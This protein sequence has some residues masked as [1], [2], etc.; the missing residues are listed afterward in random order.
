VAFG[1]SS[2][3][4]LT[5]RASAGS[6]ARTLGVTVR[7]STFPETKAKM[8]PLRSISIALLISSA[9]ACIP[10]LAQDTQETR[11]VAMQRYLRAVPMAKMMEDTY[12]EMAKQVPP[13]KRTEFIGAMRKIVR[14]DKIEEIAKRAMLKTFTTSELNALADFYSSKDGASAMSKFG[15][16]MGDIMPPLMEEI[17]RAVQELQTGKK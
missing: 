11:Q 8:N 5:L 17:Q 1:A 2:R 4:R 3:T 9:S 6:L 13:E 7:P 15:A 10:A 12:S 16:Y 14:V